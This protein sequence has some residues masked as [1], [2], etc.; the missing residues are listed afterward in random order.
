MGTKWNSTKYSGV[1][2]REHK[3]RKHGIK[4]DQYFA[5]R[6]QKDGKRKEEGIGWASEGWT[7][8]KVALKLGELKAAA[9][10]GEGESRLSDARAKVKAE[11][12]QEQ[13]RQ[14][15]EEKDN[16][17]LSTYFDE[18]YYP[19]IS[20]E[21]KT[22]TAVTE[23]QLFR[24]WIK[25]T[26]GD[27]PLKDISA[28]DL[29]RLKK[30]MLKE[31]RAPRSV[32]YALTTLGQIFRHAERLDYY[33]GDIPTT[34]VKKPKYDNKRVRFLSHDEAHTLLEILQKK[35]QETYEMALLSL[36]C[37]L[38]AGEVF[39]LTWKDIDLDHGLV[40]LLDTKSGKTR[41]VS[42]TADVQSFFMEKDTGSK[43]DLIFPDRQT[44]GIRKQI[45]K[46][47]P[48]AVSETGL[49][50]GIEDRRQRVTFH[51]LRHTFASWLVMNGISLYD[52]K[53]LLG[54]ATLTMTERYAHL[55]PD[56]NKK[57]AA[58]MEKVFQKDK[59]E[60]NKVVKLA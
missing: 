36:H 10:T 8:Q 48:R 34:K 54:H 7:P 55:A 38:R 3:T 33:Q 17:S 27:K 42:M 47:F 2:Y 53:E 41:T 19:A 28:F 5:I 49:N 31:G 50:D 24:L 58:T 43:Q 51:T 13:A 56:R 39:S 32:E 4:P 14:E 1:R 11:K 15:Q 9:T 22:K 6:Y 40:T 60:G 45:S 26:M 59:A 57:A 25:T 16:M 20:Q 52:V 23:E 30:A 29:E 44:G 35:S 37:G 18:I 21:K 46:S 12:Q